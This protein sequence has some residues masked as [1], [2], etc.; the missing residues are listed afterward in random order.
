[1]TSAWPGSTSPAGLNPRRGR[2]RARRAAEDPMTT[3][4]SARAD[5]LPAVIDIYNYEVEHGVA[6]FDTV[7]WTLEERAPWF[8]VHASP[9]HPL[10]RVV[11]MLVRAGYRGGAALEIFLGLKLLLAPLLTVVFLQVNAHLVRP[12]RVCAGGRGLGLRPSRPPRAR[13]RARAA[14]RPDRAR[15]RGGSRRPA[16]A[17]REQRRR[18]PRAPPRARLPADRHHAAGGREV[19]PAARRRAARPAPGHAGRPLTLPP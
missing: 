11:L 14:R 10:S 4:R 6:T 9:Q 2:R 5:D 19:G 12:L 1:M 15:P 13:H 16:G 18:E 3:I 17:H 8:A 7:P